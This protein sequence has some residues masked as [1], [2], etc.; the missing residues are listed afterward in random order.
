VD[1]VRRAARRLVW[2][3]GLA[4]FAAAVITVI[5]AA[6][7]ADYVLRREDLALRGL[8][9]V[10]ALGLVIAAFVRFAW[11]VVWPA[12]GRVAIARRV[13]RRFPELGE[14][15]SS[16]IALLAEPEGNPVAGSIALRRAV[17]AD[18]EAASARL[19]FREAVDASA[20]RRASLYAG[21]AVALAVTVFAL[22]STAAKLALF[23]LA[24]PWREA[25]WPRRHELALVEPPGQIAAG[26]D[27]E[28]AV[29]D[30]RGGLPDPVE[31]LI[32]RQTSAGGHTEVKP[33]QPQGNQMVSR[34]EKVTQG[35]DYRARGG[36]D[37]TMPWHTLAVIKP[38]AVTELSVSVEPPAYT[39][40]PPQAMGRVVKGLIGSRLRASG[41]LDRS[42]RSVVV[43]S[44]SSAVSLPAV[45][46]SADGRSFTAGSDAPWILER[47]GALWFE[48]A[49]EHG[50]TFVRDTRITLQAVAD[51]PPTIAWETPA[52][53]SMVT[54]RAILPVKALIKDDLTLRAVHLHFL[55]PAGEAEQSIEL[56]S[57]P[58]TAAP[59]G[60]QSIDGQSATIDYPWD[61][62]QLP[63][64]KPG[65]E[66]VVRLTAED[67]QPQLAQ[68]ATRRLIIIADAE[69]ASR[70]ASLQ[71]A[72][73]RQL[74]DALDV[75][76][77]GRA[78]T[79]ALEARLRDNSSLTDSDLNRLQAAQHGLRR[80]EQML[81]PTPQGIE[82]RIAALL[83]EL[84]ANR[85][86]GHAA[87]QRLNELMANIRDVNRGTSGGLSSVDQHL[88]SAYKAARAAIDSAANP[89][90][91]AEVNE[92][93]RAAGQAQDSVVQA[94]EH[95]VGIL[96]DWDN[97]QRLTRE[98]RQIRDDQERLAVETD[99]L[100]IKTIAASEMAD[101]DRTAAKRQSQRQSD[102]ARQLDKWQL[103][104]EEMVARHQDSD[105]RASAAAAEAVTTAKQL[106]IGGQMREAAS[107]LAQSRFGQAW[108]SERAALDGLN[109][110][111][112]KLSS[113]S[114][115]RPQALAALDGADTIMRLILLRTRQQDIN[116]RT[117]TLEVTRGERPLTAKELQQL[118]ALSGEQG[119][120]A[121]EILN[122]ARS[123]ADGE[124]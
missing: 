95:M 88:T 96:A 115:D 124:K 68:S 108:H 61:L 16:A 110:I 103:Q 53:Q 65:D 91:L 93:L 19:D 70:I 14:R 109:Q 119:Q 45:E 56:Y 37:D 22:N 32:R 64:L 35:F 4:R 1:Q 20:A 75:A 58:S 60:N 81:D 33:M 78:A 74:S 12:F 83:Q 57:A 38:P 3:H 85:L 66:L 87:E 104:I 21:I 10:V 39:G 7:L 54:A 30:R 67:H 121:E 84:A 79:S 31:L 113:S 26:D 107:Q 111:V 106:A 2:L 42:I 41:R 92:S 123:L 94:L 120:L 97:T 51:L 8:L 23:R 62:A 46:L 122:I 47:S 25:P 80:L 49:D 105:P 48:M 24:M 13:E 27:F 90:A 116:L 55:L 99:Q 82:G 114:H 76:R 29:I 89:Q 11:P 118:D 6:G 77:Q 15:L 59:P 72:I 102:L 69:L 112:T 28:V 17:V 5:V 43:R 40:L 63:D 73:L 117:A 86:Q 36:D 100:R 34:L 101:S 44:E 71:G 52:D 18:A 50:L 9:S 98:V